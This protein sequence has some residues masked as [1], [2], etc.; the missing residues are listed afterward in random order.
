MTVSSR[1]RYFLYYVNINPLDDAIPLLLAA[2][3]SAAVCSNLDIT[4][5]STARLISSF[6]KNYPLLS[7]RIS[8]FCCDHPSS[9]S[10]PLISCFDSLITSKTIISN[11][12]HVERLCLYRWIVLASW[13]ETNS[14]S[15]SSV[16]CI[17]W[18]TI[19][20][21]D[22]PF[23]IQTSS[24]S[25]IAHID[26]I[27]ATGPLF[28]VCPNFIYLTKSILYRYL[29]YLSSFLT[30]CQNRL[31]FALPFFNDIIAWSPII[32][33]DYLCSSCSTITSWNQ[34][35]H[36]Y[37]LYA[38]INFRDRGLPGFQFQLCRYLI[39]DKRFNYSLN[40]FPYFYAKSLF[41]SNRQLCL[42]NSDHSLYVP[43]LCLHFQ[44]TEGK[45][46]F[47]NYVVPLLRSIEGFDFFFDFIG[48]LPSK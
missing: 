15:I 25:M 28:Q 21:R 7:S 23:E 13:F 18:D 5:A 9:I 32:S 2:N 38:D 43:P 45:F 46:I 44:G 10:D 27:E 4:L 19:F 41:V 47:F 17:D 36:P 37:N 26:S 16:I 48:H 39:D 24:H 3:L 33:K 1:N 30:E 14:D 12:P 29:D 11:A 40:S 6:N 22:L 31:N 20:F 34:L 35:L 42:V 8:F